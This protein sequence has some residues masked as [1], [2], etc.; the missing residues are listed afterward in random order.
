MVEMCLMEFLLYSYFGPYLPGDLAH[1]GYS[2]KRLSTYLSL[3]T[4][5]IF[6]VPLGVSANF[7]FLFIHFIVIQFRNENTVWN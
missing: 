6:G 4:D 7:I 5:G 1:R 2:I 3:S